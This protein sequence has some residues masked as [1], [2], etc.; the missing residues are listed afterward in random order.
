[1]KGGDTERLSLTPSQ[2]ERANLTKEIGD[3]SNQIESLGAAK[4]AQ[5]LANAELRDKLEEAGLKEERMKDD[6]VSLVFGDG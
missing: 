5:E 4:R 1:M 3:L 6:M 2:L